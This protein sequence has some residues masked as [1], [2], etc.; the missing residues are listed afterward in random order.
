VNL[1]PLRD[2]IVVRP[3]ERVKSQV[4]DVVMSE[5]PNTGEILAVG[6]GEVD[7]KG[8]FIPNPL[9][10]GQRIRFGTAE[11]YLSYPRCEV[12]GEELIVMSWKDVCFYRK[13]WP[14]PLTS[15]SPKR[16]RARAR[17]TTQRPKA[18]V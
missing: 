11:E 7:K 15:P 5:L 1:R 13:S 12:D 18:P 3:I 2:R 17:P 10:I 6:P 9:E 8:R 4:I 16:P 14:K